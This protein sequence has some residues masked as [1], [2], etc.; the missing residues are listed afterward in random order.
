MS[1]LSNLRTALSNLSDA[2]DV[3]RKSGEGMWANY[4][5]TCCYPQQPETVEGMEAIHKRTVDDLNNIRELSKDEKN[6]LRSAKSV[7]SKAIANGVDV[8]K[9]DESG[10]II[11]DDNGNPTPKG[12]SELQEAKSDFDRL[13]S[14][15]EQFG[16]TFGKESRDPLLA[17]QLESL[18][19]ELLIV[20]SN[21][22]AEYVAV[23]GE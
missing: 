4:V 15:L 20:A 8:W 12:K 21:V 18:K 10:C 13:M 16:K 19:G 14:L 11:M 2:K 3:S 1:F 22:G 23:C 6:S 9:R 17:E 7:I 5:R